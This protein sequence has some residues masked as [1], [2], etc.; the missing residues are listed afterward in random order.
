M[1]E[2]PEVQTIA[3]SLKE[4]EGSQILSLIIQW[5]KSYVGATRFDNVRIIKISRR[6]KYIKMLL[7]SNEHLYI[8][9]RMSG[10]LSVENSKRAYNRHEHVVFSLSSN[11]F[12]IFH[13]TRKFGRI[14]RTNDYIKFESK[15][16]VEPF[17]MDI[18]ETARKMIEKKRQLKALLLDQSFIAGLGNIYV[19]E[20]LFEAKLHPLKKASSLTFKEAF[21]LLE[22]CKTVLKRGLENQGT[23]LG[24]GKANY[25]KPNGKNGENQ[26]ALKVFRK[27]GL[28]CPECGGRIERMIIVQRS[29]HFCPNCQLL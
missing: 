1:P 20:A 19:D 15:L 25:L 11:K 24:V 14:V 29:S 6:A 26:H 28:A 21:S 13:D 3:D 2:L 18:E 5:K 12:L 7:S 10:R 4:I 16:G 23:S 17:E 27:T 22:A 8:H 9:L